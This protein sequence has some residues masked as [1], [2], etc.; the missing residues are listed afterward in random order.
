MSTLV[1]RL[2]QERR[3]TAWTRG[4]DTDYPT[5]WEPHALSQE[6]ADEIER[7]RAALEKIADWDSLWGPFP[8]RNEYWRAMVVVTAREA[9]P[10]SV[11]VAMKK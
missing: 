8:E 7:L 11:D 3:P 4:L 5:A 6:A 9:V 2:R 10:R 1:E